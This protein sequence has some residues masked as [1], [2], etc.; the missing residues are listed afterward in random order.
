[1]SKFVRDSALDAKLDDINDAT[2]YYVCTGNPTTR[3][4][5]ITNSLTASP[6]TPTF[7]SFAD[8]T[9]SGRELAVDQKDFSINAGGTAATVCLC[10]GSVLVAKTDLN[11]TVVVSASQTLTVAAWKVTGT[12]AE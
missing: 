7:Q 10:T 3:A 12:D 9:P 5:A 1:M 6:V 4:E 8:G 2:E 11:P